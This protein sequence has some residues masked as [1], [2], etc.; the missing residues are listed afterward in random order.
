MKI[1]VQG[2]AD[3]NK[4]YDERNLDTCVCGCGRKFLTKKMFLEFLKQYEDIDGE[5]SILLEYDYGK[6]VQKIHVIVETKLESMTS[7]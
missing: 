7:K 4:V 1:N 3:D 2:L 5:A 6:M